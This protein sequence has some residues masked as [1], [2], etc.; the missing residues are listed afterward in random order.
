MEEG[1]W[2]LTSPIPFDDVIDLPARVA[3]EIKKERVQD[4]R[5]DRRGDVDELLDLADQLAKATD[6]VE[7]LQASV[8]LIAQAA[9]R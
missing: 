4:Q 3:W 9:P 2:H 6:E 8:S 7:Q 1:V 5:A